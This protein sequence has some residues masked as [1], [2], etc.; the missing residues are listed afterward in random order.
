[1]ECEVDEMRAKMQ[2]WA[3]GVES[4]RARA[5]PS[6][7]LK[8]RKV[9]AKQA[10]GESTPLPPLQTDEAMCG[11]QLRSED[12]RI[13]VLTEPARLKPQ[14]DIAQAV[15][16]PSF[17]DPVSVQSYSKDR[18]HR[19]PQ[20]APQEQ[21]ERFRD[22]V[23]EMAGIVPNFAAKSEKSNQYLQRAEPQ[24]QACRYEAPQLASMP[25]KESSKRELGATVELSGS[26]TP[27]RRASLNMTVETGSSVQHNTHG[28]G[29]L[30]VVEGT[31]PYLVQS[32]DGRR[33]SCTPLACKPL[34]SR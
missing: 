5:V 14:C 4:T 1:M 7:N 23:S 19:P 8:S 32:D 2:E 17:Y 26:P 30:E 11:E 21:R 15:P 24:K 27:T 13:T 3:D 9:T 25:Q 31:K 12:V 28:F 18:H 20:I 16:E 33:H 22:I 34:P 29:I 6:P 10:D